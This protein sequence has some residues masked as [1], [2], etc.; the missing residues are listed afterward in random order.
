MSR[1]AHVSAYYAPAWRYGGPPRSIHGL[2]RALCASGVDV[3]VFTT[4]ADGAGSL[5][6]A[7]TDAGQFEGVPVRYF[8]RSWPAAPIGSRALTAALRQALPS[9][10]VVHI[11]GLWN[12]VTW[13]A[14]R[15]AARA[16]V[17]YVVS[18]RGM[19]QTAALAH[20]GWRKRAAFAAIERGV[21]KGAAFL[22]AT[23]AAEVEALKALDLGPAIAL[24]PNGIDL[25][26]SAESRHTR[27]RTGFEVAFVGRL[28]PI[29]RLDLLIDAFVAL[30]AANPHAR[31]SIAGPDEYGLRPSLEL[32]AGSVNGDIT[33]HGEVGASRRDELLRQAD[34]LVLCSDSES[35]G[36]SALE[37]M[38]AATP[39]VVTTTC[40]WDS[41]EERGAGLRVEQSSAAIA[42]AL[43]R[44]MRDPALA[45]AM[46][47][48]GRQL[49]ESCYAWPGVARAFAE[50][51]R[52]LR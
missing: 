37:A 17:P 10:D 25:Q 48:R 13:S 29:K 9:L 38:A 33:W 7:I 45:S 8:T 6:A 4:D 34:A 5:P 36:M 11:H 22:H 31:L 27:D 14:A 41:L 18:P 24:I 21:L 15:E 1:V 39:V 26:G 43:T 32:R 16:G 49:A 12:R 19:L 40:G 47:A 52:Q 51:Y 42:E 44:L 28:H 23:S 30:R 35:F 20:H 2:C 50:R 46:G 3:R